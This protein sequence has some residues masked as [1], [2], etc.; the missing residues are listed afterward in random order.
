MLGWKW[1]MGTATGSVVDDTGVP[2][3]QIDGYSDDGSGGPY[4]ESHT[5]YGFHSVPLD[6]DATGACLVLFAQEGS[7]VHCWPLGDARGLAKIP[8]LPKG[9]SCQYSCSGMFAEMDPKT[10]TYTLYVPTD[11]DGAGKATKAHVLTIGKDA[12]GT[13]NFNFL[14]AAGMRITIGDKAGDKNGIYIANAANNAWLCVNDDGVEINGN[15][16]VLGNMG[17]GPLLTAWMT[18]VQAACAAASPPIVI[19]VPPAISLTA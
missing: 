18:A 1:D 2:T 14:H 17:T 11:F 19:P 7:R 6:P 5:P 9:G 16:K 3:I 13:R 8:K 15:L 4:G 12:N 10:N